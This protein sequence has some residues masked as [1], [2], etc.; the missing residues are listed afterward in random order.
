MRFLLSTLVVLLIGTAQAKPLPT[1]SWL[2]ANA[3]GTVMQGENVQEVRP[4]ASISKLMTVMIVMDANQALDEKLGNFTRREHI[5][6]ALVRSDNNSARVLCENY[7]GGHE[8]CVRAMNAKAVDL[9]MIN[10]H[11]IEPTGLSV[12]NVSTAK[13]LVHLVL[14][15]KKYPVIIEAGHTSTTKIKLKKHWMSV[16]NTNPMIGNDPR[17]VIS[18]TG[19]INAA[20]G[21]IVLLLDTE[22]GQ[23]VVVLLGSKNTHTRIPEAKLIISKAN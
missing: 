16:R 15:S 12:F 2:V 6:L 10:T 17:I 4:I 13:D 19:F 18:K 14:A 22:L 5:Q 20:G 1:E 23:R 9:N 3:D 8:Q 7:P 11:F 21:C